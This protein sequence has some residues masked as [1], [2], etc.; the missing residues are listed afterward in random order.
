MNRCMQTVLIIMLSVAGPVFPAQKGKPVFW[1]FDKSMEK[2]NPSCHK[3]AGTVY[4]TDIM[5]TPDFATNMRAIS[6]G[7]FLPE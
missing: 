7:R 4:L 5:G 3:G 1:R 2:P 6:R